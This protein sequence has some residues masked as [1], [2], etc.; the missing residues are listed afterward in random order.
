MGTEARHT[1]REIRE[2]Q[3]K[4]HDIRGVLLE[5]IILASVNSKQYGHASLKM[6]TGKDMRQENWLQVLTR[7][8]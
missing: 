1:H 6:F 5:G 3:N 8:K 2:E 7:L 4:G